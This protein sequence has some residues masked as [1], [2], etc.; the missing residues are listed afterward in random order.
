MWNKT[1]LLRA[2]RPPQCEERQEPGGDH[3]A[4]IR[5]ITSD[6]LDLLYVRGGPGVNPKYDTDLWPAGL[7][8]TFSS[9]CPATRQ[10]QSYV[11]DQ[12]DGT[13]DNGP[14]VHKPTTLSAELDKLS[15]T[16]WRSRLVPVQPSLV[17][18]GLVQDG[19]G[20]EL[21]LRLFK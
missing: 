18:Y 8:E 13:E 19:A 10:Q 15:L 6:T 5:L 17:Q 1:P 21:G 20:H 3:T 9:G 11:E 12:R 14:T 16:K 7:T 4:T 2:T